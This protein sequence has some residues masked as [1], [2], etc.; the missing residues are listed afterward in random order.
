[1]QV[2]LL[3]LFF[4]FILVLSQNFSHTNCNID[5]EN[6]SAN[7]HFL[8]DNISL[9]CNDINKTFVS[10]FYK[11]SCNSICFDDVSYSVYGYPDKIDKRIYAGPSEVKFYYILAEN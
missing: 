6:I 4:S 5:F 1:M 3:I 9:I 2:K 7:L 10:E 8:G 11:D